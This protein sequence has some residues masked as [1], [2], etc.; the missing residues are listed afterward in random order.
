MAR[1][2]DAPPELVLLDVGLPDID[3]LEVLFAA[4]RV[5][6]AGDLGDGP[7]GEVDR[8]VGLGC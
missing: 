1:A 5:L 4:A 6:G 8:L 3:G 2:S 7:R